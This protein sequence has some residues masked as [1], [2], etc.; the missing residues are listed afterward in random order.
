[1]WAG[2]APGFSH[3]LG[4]TIMGNTKKDSVTDSYGRTH[5]IANLFIVGPGLFPTEGAV[6]P[7]FSIH[8]LTLRTADYMKTH[9]GSAA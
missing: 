6:N 2:P 8:A 1:V 9:W 5:D 7:T 4:G 3:L